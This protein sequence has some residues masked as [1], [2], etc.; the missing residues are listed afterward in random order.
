MRRLPALCLAACVL[1]PGLAAAQSQRCEDRDKIIGILA[2]KYGE[3]R[4]A[5]GLTAKGAVVETYAS[6]ASGSWTITVTFP[7]GR[8]C[9][10][11]SG[12]SF[13]ALQDAGVPSG[14]PA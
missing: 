5:I 8:T 13:E 11:A 4:R 10:L 1:M 12:Q 9:L 7:D 6:E 14:A 2:D 3:S